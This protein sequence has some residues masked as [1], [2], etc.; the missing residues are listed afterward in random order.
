MS[1][2]FHSQQ[3][4]DGLTEVRF[5]LDVSSE[6]VP[7]ALFL[8]SDLDEPSPLVFIQHPG[9]GSKDDYFVR[10]PS[11]LW[12]RKGWICAGLDAPMHGDRASHDPLSM[13]RDREAMPRVVAQFAAEVTAAIDA[14]AEHFPVDT[15]RIGYIGYSL[16]SMLGIPA[17][18]RDGRFKAAAFCLVGEG[19]LVGPASGEGS[20]VPG[21]ANVA[22][23]IVAKTHDELIPR[24]RTEALFEALSGERDIVWRPGGHFEIGTD[25]IDA[26]RDWLSEK[27]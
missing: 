25:V 10:E 2:Q 17:V 15:G 4:A 24:E 12:A 21:L 23:R 1:A 20:D 19:G 3:V 13:F 16:G 7:G 27:L 8:P 5:I 14:I 26:A 18:A 11:M 22:V 9:M 6:R